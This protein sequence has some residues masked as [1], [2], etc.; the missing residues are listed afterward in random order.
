[1]KSSI[2]FIII[3]A[4]VLFT[5]CQPGDNSDPKDFK[6]DSKKISTRL[7]I[8]HDFGRNPILDKNIEVDYGATAIDVL[9]EQADAATAYGGGFITSIEGIKSGYMSTPYSRTDWFLYING[10]LTNVGGMSYK[11][12]P[13]DTVHWYYR[14]W[15]FRQSVTALVSDYPE[16]FIKGYGGKTR[17]TTILYQTDWEQKASSLAD[18]LTQAGVT[19]I[20]TST[21]DALSS[22]EMEGHNIIVIG[23]QDFMPVSYVNNVWNKLGLYAR[24]DKSELITY[25]S[26]G[27]ITESYHTGAGIIF[28]IQ[29]PFNPRGTGACE[30]VLWII[31]GIDDSGIMSAI[32]VL[33]AEPE[34]LNYYAGAIVNNST[35]HPLP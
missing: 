1:V 7:V 5:G 34:K 4:V 19:D 21:L 31:S 2:F 6:G 28:A 8:S 33:L 9:K 30:N 14:D 17:P 13:G 27:N 24:F 16:P 26:G 22:S 25:D 18:K 12:Q 35:V 23:S 10:F 20:R 29:N 32:D 11:I 15:S 3:S